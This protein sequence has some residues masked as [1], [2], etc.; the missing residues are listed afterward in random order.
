MKIN[1]A[2][3]PVFLFFFV[4][5]AWAQDLP[6]PGRRLSKTEQEMDPEK[7]LLE[8]QRKAAARSDVFRTERYRDPEIC[9]RARLNKQ[10]SCGAPH[11]HQSRSMQCTAAHAYLDENCY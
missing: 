1:R 7:L 9:E 2:L 5:L 4:S 6:D 8:Q 3:T 10:I 11:S